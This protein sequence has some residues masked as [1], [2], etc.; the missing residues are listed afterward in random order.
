MIPLPDIKGREKILRVHTRK[1]PLAQDVEL[2][3]IAKA[4]P[5]FYWSRTSELGE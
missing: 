5:W 2:T 4:T 1:T 3:V